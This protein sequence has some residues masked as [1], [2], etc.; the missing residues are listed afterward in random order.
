MGVDSMLHG[1]GGVMGNYTFQEIT[2]PICNRPVDLAKERYTD[3][4]GKAVHEDCY[5]QRLMCALNEPPD[6]HHAE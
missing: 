1:A 4:S 2:C 6:P 5:L 3:E